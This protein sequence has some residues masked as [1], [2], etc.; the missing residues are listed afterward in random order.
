MPIERHAVDQF[1]A[2]HLADRS[3]ALFQHRRFRSDGQLLAGTADFERR[4]EHGA[5]V[6][7]KFDGQAAYVLNPACEISSTYTPGSRYGTW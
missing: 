6:H 7:V 5:I 3:V 1:M 4:I 2:D